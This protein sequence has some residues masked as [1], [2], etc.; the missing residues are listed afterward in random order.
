MLLDVNVVVLLGVLVV[1]VLGPAVID[2]LR[3][4]RAK[5]TWRH[6]RDGSMGYLK[7]EWFKTR[8]LH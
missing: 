4:S 2:L 1:G 3:T 5:Q 7:V 8:M 6:D